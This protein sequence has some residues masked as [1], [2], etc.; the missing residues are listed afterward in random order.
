MPYKVFINFLQPLKAFAEKGI[1]PDGTNALAPTE[2][3]DNVLI[4]KMLGGR[5]LLS[6]RMQIRP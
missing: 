6:G 5:K 1:V 3:C 4:P 2:T